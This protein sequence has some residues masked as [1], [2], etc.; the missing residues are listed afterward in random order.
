M[1]KTKTIFRLFA[2]A[3]VL[4][5][6]MSC[7]QADKVAETGELS[8]PEITRQNKPWTRWWWPASAVGQSD[9][10]DMLNPIARQILVVSR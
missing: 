1:T 9:I 8:W 4:A 6:A 7:G 2:F 10:D 5:G 3:L